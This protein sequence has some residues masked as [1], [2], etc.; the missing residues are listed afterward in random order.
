M[1]ATAFNGWR[2][3]ALALQGWYMVCLANTQGMPSA[4]QSMHLR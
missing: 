2:P 3:H 1:T 4:G